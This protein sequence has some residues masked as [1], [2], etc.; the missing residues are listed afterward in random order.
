[1]PTA[2][3][4]AAILLLTTLFLA[5]IGCGRIPT[6]LTGG[7]MTSYARPFPADLHQTEQ[8]NIQARRSNHRVTLTNS[9]PERFEAGTLWI[10][11]RFSKPIQSLDIGQT[12]TLDLRNFVDQHGEQFRGGG[13]FA[14]ERPADVM[15]FQL[16]TTRNNETVLLGMVSVGQTPN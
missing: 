3:M 12:I 7:P 10:N 4:L 15:L 11:R 14:T 2:R 9:T 5:L 16:E 13:F 8:L 1:M 6:A